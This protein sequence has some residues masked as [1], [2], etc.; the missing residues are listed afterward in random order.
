MRG[1]GHRD[2]QRVPVEDGDPSLVAGASQGDPGQFQGLGGLAQIV[3][4]RADPDMTGGG[5][6]QGA[7][8]GLDAGV[9]GGHPH[10]ADF[11]VVQQPPRGGHAER[12]KRVLDAH[13]R[14]APDVGHLSSDD[15]VRT[16]C[17]QPQ[18]VGGLP[19]VGVVQAAFEQRL[20]YG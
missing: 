3:V 1:A 18:D 11:G 8:E 12:P 16:L 2:G 5:G 4:G 10:D 14:M 6:L 20:Y 15:H 19:H 13:E 9:G 17:R 7:G